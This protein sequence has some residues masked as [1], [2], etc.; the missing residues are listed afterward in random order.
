MTDADAT[1]RY[2]PPTPA[3]L[4]A[5]F[6]EPTPA[7][8]LD[9]CAHRDACLRLLATLDGGVDEKTD[10]WQAAAAARLGCG[11]CEEWE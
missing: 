8:A 5:M 6:A 2:A 1:P 3:E 10:G 4:A 7:E 9:G 11:D